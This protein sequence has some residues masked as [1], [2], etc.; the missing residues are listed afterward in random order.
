MCSDARR[1]FFDAPVDFLSDAPNSPRITGQGHLML[2]RPPREHDTFFTFYTT[3]LLTVLRVLERIGVRKADAPDIAQLVFLKIHKNL[4][5][6]PTERV[7]AW[8]EVIC[9]QQAADHYRLYRNRFETPTPNVGDDIPDS[10]DVHE[11]FERCEMETLVKKVLDGMDAP[12]REVLIRYEFHDESLES[13]A[14]SLGIVRNTVHARLVEAKRIFAIRAK[15]LLGDERRSSMF[16]P[17]FVGTDALSDADLQSSA[18]VEEMR[19]RIWDGIASNLGL[20]RD[21]PAPFEKSRSAWTRIL[22]NRVLVATS[23]AVAGFVAAWLWPRD[24][25]PIAK[26]WAMSA[27]TIVAENSESTRVLE[28]SALTLAITSAAPSFA[29]WAPINT[30][31]APDSRVDRELRTLEEARKFVASARYAEAIA[32]LTQHVREF[33]KSQFASTR[34]RYMSLAQEGRRRTTP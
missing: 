5:K 23:S 9:K 26:H 16:V 3:Y 10:N 14:K 18:F 15:K 27:P 1:N 17:L 7:H 32:A 6:R 20:A 33:P 25:P 29:N 31:T 30:A 19:T 24:V 2:Q 8:I 22:G 28:K 4:E 11:Q 34:S 13:I 21:F 12:L